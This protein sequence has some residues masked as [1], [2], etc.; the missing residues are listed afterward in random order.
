M[1]QSVFSGNRLD[2]AALYWRGRTRGTSGYG[3]GLAALESY[4]VYQSALAD[5]GSGENGEM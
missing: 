5:I 4:I 1:P 2:A 3:G